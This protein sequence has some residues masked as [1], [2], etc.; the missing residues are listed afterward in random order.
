MDK[1]SW[2]GSNYH[3]FQALRSDGCLVNVV[4]ADI[5]GLKRKYFILK[6]FAFNMDTWRFKL[7]LDTTM[8][9]GRSKKILGIIR[10]L[11][12]EFNCTLQI[13]SEFSLIRDR[14]IF[15]KP[16]FAYHDSNLHAYLK[17]PQKLPCL[18]KIIDKALGYEKK[19]YD[20]LDM[21]FTM[22]DYLGKIFIEDFQIPENNS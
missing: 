4:D 9:Q 3:L 11:E 5:Y 12:H 20:D 19:I 7:H 22:T 6:N 8:R 1:G 15:S 2:S 13:G 21:I 10:E 16:K 18:P 14:K 17:S